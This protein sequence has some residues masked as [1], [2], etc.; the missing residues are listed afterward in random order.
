MT[1]EVTMERE[2]RYLVFKLTDVSRY[3]DGADD[4]A[5]RLLAMRIALGRER[6]GRAALD[7]V[8]VE[9]DWPEYEPTWAAIAARMEGGRSGAVTMGKI[10]QALAELECVLTPSR[11]FTCQALALLSFIR[12]YEQQATERALRIVREEAISVRHLPNTT[13]KNIERRIKEESKLT[14]SASALQA[15]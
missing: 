5:L 2:I 13:I 8:V 1:K 12:Q 6:D 9:S 11:K 14:A 15:D 3:L 7:T 10:E 4:R